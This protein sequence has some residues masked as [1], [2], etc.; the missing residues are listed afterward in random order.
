[1]AKQTAFS[2][3]GP[4]QAKIFSHKNLAEGKLT[5]LAKNLKHLEWGEVTWLSRI[6]DFYREKE[7]I[8]EKQLEVLH[9]L[10]KKYANQ[11]S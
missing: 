10:C 1:M 4:I 11:A 9:S 6:E 2:F 8:T 3:E 5:F 7:Y